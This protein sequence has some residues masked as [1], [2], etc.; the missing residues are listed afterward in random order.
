MK[1]HSQEYLRRPV[2]DSRI[3]EIRHA[4]KGRW[5]SGLFNNIIDLEHAIRERA[6]DGNLYT[7]LNRP[8]GIT[9][10][11]AFGARALRDEN[12]ETITRIVFD[13]DPKRPTNTPSTDDELEAALKARDLVVRVLTA[14]GWPRPALGLSGNGAHAVYRACLVSSPAWRQQGATLYAGLRS[15]LQDQLTDLGVEFDVTVRNPGRIWRLYGCMNRKGEATHDRPHRRATIT[16]PAGAWQTVKA[17]TISRTVE[18]LTPVVTRDRATVRRT[19]PHIDGNGDFTTLDVIS[20]F[21][22]HDAYR[23]PLAEGKHAVTCPWAAE[24]TTT[25]PNGT[26]SVIWEADSG[27]PRFHCSHAHCDGRT[28]RDVIALWGDAD[29]FCSREWRRGHG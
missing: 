10:G 1:D 16:L 3:V 29:A 8:T 2:Q 11:N 26:D 7:S 18:A 23:R 13:L 24:H 4:H 20:W 12:I 15:R 25:S 17:E 9:A 22:A 14:H 28:V 21:T 6:G 5:E 19:Q 27:W